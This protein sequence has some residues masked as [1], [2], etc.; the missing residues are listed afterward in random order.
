MAYESIRVAVSKSQ[1][2]IPER[3]T[4][5]PVPERGVDPSRGR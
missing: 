3:T 4:R 1:D 5:K 2:G